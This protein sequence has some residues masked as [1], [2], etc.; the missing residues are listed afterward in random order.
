MSETPQ[1]EAATPVAPAPA[2]IEAP[3][4]TRR[5]GPHVAVEWNPC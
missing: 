5:F 2:A 1:P 4:L 3:N